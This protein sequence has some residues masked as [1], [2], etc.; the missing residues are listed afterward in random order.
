MAIVKN[1]LKKFQCGRMLVSVEP[2]ATLEDN[3][4]KV[5]DL[6]LALRRLNVSETA[7]TVRKRPG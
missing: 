4:T 2:T 1:W 3:V 5:H 6:I 7:D